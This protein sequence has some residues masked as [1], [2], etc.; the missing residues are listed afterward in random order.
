MTLA[1]LKPTTCITQDKEITFI[2]ANLVPFGE[3]RNFYTKLVSRG[4][5]DLEFSNP[6]GSRFTGFGQKFR[7]SLYLGFEINQ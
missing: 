3:S 7:I 2:S 1:Y 6:A 5:P 4:A